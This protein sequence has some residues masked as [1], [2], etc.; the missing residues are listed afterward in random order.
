MSEYKYSKTL[1]TENILTL[2]KDK[3]VVSIFFVYFCLMKSFTVEWTYDTYHVK[4]ILLILKVLPSKSTGIINKWWI[5]SLLV[6]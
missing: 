5:H 1:E 6:K 3:A 2:C 4:T